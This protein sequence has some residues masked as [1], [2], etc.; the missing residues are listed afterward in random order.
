MARETYRTEIK[1][2]EDLNGTRKAAVLTAIQRYYRGIGSVDE[3]MKLT[4]G[5]FTA[6]EKAWKAHLKDQLSRRRR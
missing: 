1:S 2:V 6:F 5:D 3:F 4:G